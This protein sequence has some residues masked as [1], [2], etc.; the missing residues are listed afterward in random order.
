[1]RSF[2]FHR[3]HPGVAHTPSISNLLPLSFYLYFFDEQKLFIS[4][5]NCI[6]NTGD[7]LNAQRY[8]FF[9]TARAWLVLDTS[10][11][12]E[13]SVKWFFL[14]LHSLLSDTILNCNLK[15][16]KSFDLL[17]QRAPD[18]ARY[19][20]LCIFTETVKRKERQRAPE[21]LNIDT[22]KAKNYH[23]ALSSYLL[24]LTA[25]FVHCSSPKLCHLRK[26]TYPEV[27]NITQ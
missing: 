11:E 6:T 22:L 1:M 12:I 15:S 23:W 21:K 13:K 7:A 25:G 24:S 4:F 8:R 27:L 18:N 3:Q 20:L 16:V 9:S 5:L 2:I 14:R 10:N 26:V 17:Q 19:I